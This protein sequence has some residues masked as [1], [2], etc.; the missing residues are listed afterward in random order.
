MKILIVLP[1]R[2]VGGGQVVALNLAKALSKRH[3]V[4][5]MIACPEKSD[6]QSPKIPEGVE[7]IENLPGYLSH[8]FPRLAWLF[9][10]VLDFILPPWRWSKESGIIINFLN[11]RYQRTRRKH[12]LSVV[13]D[14]DFDIINSHVW[15][16]DYFI[17]ECIPES[18][19]TPWVITMHGCYESLVADMSRHPYYA[20]QIRKVL[21]RADQVLFIADKNLE[22]LTKL[23]GLRLA[24]HPVKVMNGV[25]SAS[26]SGDGLDPAISR[27]TADMLLVLV[28]RAIPEKGWEQAIEAVMELNEDSEKRVKLILVGGG[29]Y[30]SLLVQK[31]QNPFIVFAGYVAQPQ[32]VIRHCDVGLLPSYFVSESVPISVIECLSAGKPVIA[33]DLGE[34]PEMINHEGQLAGQLLKLNESGKVSVADLKAAIQRYIES[35]DL[36]KTHQAVAL[37]AARKFSMEENVEMYEN[38]YRSCF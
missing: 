6:Q 15:R 28:S 38:I 27:G 21:E 35:P 36:L 24:K 14:G 25:C 13:G 37:K 20:S 10:V 7:E 12:F 2:E 31:Y 4:K 8:Y 26:E 16:S 19:K 22:V 3:L 18:W 32:N 1:D 29:E 9:I 33:T 17:G 5:V 23:P 34:I 11:N 30:Q